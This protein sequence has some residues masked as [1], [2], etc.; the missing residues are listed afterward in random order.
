MDQLIGVPKEPLQQTEWNPTKSPLLLTI[1]KDMAKQLFSIW[2]L[3][4]VKNL[5]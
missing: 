3:Q 5:L 2:A 4:G 1:G